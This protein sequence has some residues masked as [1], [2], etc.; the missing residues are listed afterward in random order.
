[1][2]KTINKTKAV[3]LIENSKGKFFTVT[4]LKKDSTERTINANYKTGRKSPLGYINVY[5]MKDKGYRNIN[6]QT[7]RSVSINGNTYNVR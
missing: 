4:F 6:A 5:S 7:I 2:S 1:M 3:E